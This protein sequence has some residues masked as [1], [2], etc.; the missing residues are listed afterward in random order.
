MERDIYIGDLR[1]GWSKAED[2]VCVQYGMCTVAVCPEG[3]GKD[4]DKWRF[5]RKVK[6]FP[7]NGYFCNTSEYLQQYN[8]R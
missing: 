8:V 4:L 2:W 7:F 5:R 6:C 1:T 3:E